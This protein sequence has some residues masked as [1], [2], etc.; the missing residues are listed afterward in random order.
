MRTAF[1]HLLTREE[2]LA[3]LERVYLGE[4]Q[5]EHPNLLE[6]TN[7][8][9]LEIIKDQYYILDYFIDELLEEFLL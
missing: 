6:K 9:L 4:A 1:I 2:L 7:P 8:E 5:Q 3:I